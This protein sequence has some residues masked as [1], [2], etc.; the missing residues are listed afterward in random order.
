M[1]ISS[2]SSNKLKLFQIDTCLIA[3]S[4][5]DSDLSATRYGIC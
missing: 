3:G 1:A 2:F 4:G 5:I